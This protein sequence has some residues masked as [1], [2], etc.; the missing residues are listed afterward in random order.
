[1]VRS[2]LDLPLKARAVFF[3]TYLSVQAVILMRA[4]RGPDFVFGFQM[5]NES[6]DLKITLLRRARYK[7]HLRLLAIRDGAWRAKDAH[8]VEH[9][10]RWQARVH[11]GVLGTLGS[12]I[13]ASYGLQAQL[14]RL[15]FALRD[16]AAHIPDDSETQALIAVV[17]TLKNGHEAGQVR[18]EASRP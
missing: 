13:H 16:V 2:L 17:D 15:Q 7:G 11:D 8:G 12:S 18:L 5:F 14:F 10:F 9:T 4:Q 6:S 1:M 3:F